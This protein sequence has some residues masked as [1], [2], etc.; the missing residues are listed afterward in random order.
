M[1]VPTEAFARFAALLERERDALVAGDMPRIEALA[2]E[3]AAALAALPPGPQ[4][5]L[6]T[7][8]PVLLRLRDLNAENGRLIAWRSQRLGD[9]LA[10]LGIGA[11]EGTTYT[12]TGYARSRFG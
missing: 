2:A 10:A 6:A 7:H 9:R 3:K 11:P 1:S 12:S 8:R 4:A 5:A